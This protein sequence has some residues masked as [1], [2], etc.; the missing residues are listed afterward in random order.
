[1]SLLW[2]G[3]IE[4]G[5]RGRNI[6]NSNFSVI[7]LTD[8]KARIPE[9]SSVPGNIRRTRLSRPTP[10]LPQPR[11]QQEQPDHRFVLRNRPVDPEEG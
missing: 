3:W 7:S 11:T 5:T 4:S 6:E 8:W 9:L 2:L 10:K 1:M